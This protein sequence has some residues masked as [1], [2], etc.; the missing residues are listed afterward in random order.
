MDLTKYDV[1]QATHRLRCCHKVGR[2]PGYNYT[3]PC[4]V[5][6]RTKSG[7]TKIVV[8]GD[9][10]WKGKDRRKRIRYVWGYKIV[11]ANKLKTQN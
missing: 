4:I 2:G 10:Y 3:M 6:G 9:R 1:S 7:K 8:F 11:E 5:L